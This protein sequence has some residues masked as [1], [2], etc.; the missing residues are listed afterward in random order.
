[1]K[2]LHGKTAL[3]VA[4]LPL[5]LAACLAPSVAWATIEEGDQSQPTDE[6][7]AAA[8]DAG[9]IETGSKDAAAV[10]K[11]DSLPYVALGAQSDISLITQGSKVSSA[12]YTIKEYSGATMY[13][14]AV[15]QAEATFT[16]SEYAI[17]AGPGDAW[18]DALSAAGLAGGLND[19]KGCPI[20]FSEKNSMHPASMQ[21][22]KKMG[23]KK[24]VIVGGTAAVGVGVEKDLEDADISVEK[25]LGGEDCYG[26]QM[27]IFNYGIN[28]NLWSGDLAIIATGTWFGDALSVSPVAYK[29][30]APIFL[31]SKTKDL[32]AAQ[33][34]AWKEAAEKGMFKEVEAVG[35]EAVISQKAVTF[36]N[37]M[38]KKA[39]GTGEVAWEWGE[40]QYE[41]SSA[42]AEYAV[43][44][45]GF[46]WNNMA[47]T[48]GQQPYDALAGSVYQG[49][50]NSVMLLADSAKASTITVAYGHHSEIKT[51]RFFGGKRALASNTR[52]GIA[53]KFGIPYASIPN[54]KLYLDAGHGYNDMGNGYYSGGATGNG[55]VENELTVELAHMVQA[56]LANE[57]GVDMFVN[58]DGGPYRYR[59]AEAVAQGCD[60]IVSIHFNATPGGSGSLTLVH[61]YNNAEMSW[62]LAEQVHPYL[63]SSMGLHDYGIWPQEVAILGGQLPAIL[64]EIC[65]IDNYYDMQIYQANKST[66]ARNIAKGIVAKP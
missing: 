8:I 7:I 34:A 49:S 16:K 60:M 50:S 12:P 18:V 26:T 42:I 39:G 32:N 2:S 19:G 62:P 14:T 37:D 31:V 15:S 53:D 3:L 11:N 22:L 30:K 48:T 24:V 61:S 59:H 28:K 4:L 40:T 36:A 21:S 41:T 66:V 43:K 54:F 5:A 38:I 25:R 46:K 55:Y 17:I 63:V 1:M 58:D 27:E 23:V 47:F 65:F 35:G 20:L 29:L 33:K 56:I 9:W 10:E 6:E 44:K 52:I 13:E 57:Y 45:Q 51:M 64:L